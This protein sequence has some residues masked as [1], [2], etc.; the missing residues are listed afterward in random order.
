MVAAEVAVARLATTAPFKAAVVTI[1][2]VAACDGAPELPV[3][4]ALLPLQAQSNPQENT[5]DHD[6]MEE[7]K[8][9]VVSQAG[10]GNLNV[11]D[12]PT[13]LGIIRFANLQD[14]NPYSTSLYGSANSIT[15]CARR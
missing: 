10:R 3:E 8:A 6:I 14:Q 5:A 9:R 13:V 15:L 7:L 12:V 1:V 2:G 11:T 4:A